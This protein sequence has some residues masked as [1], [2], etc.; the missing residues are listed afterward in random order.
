MIRNKYLRNSVKSTCVIVFYYFIIIVGRHM[1]ICIYVKSAFDVGRY[2]RFNYSNK[3]HN[4]P[5]MYNNNKTEIF[6]LWLWWVCWK[7]HYSYIYIYYI[8]II[9]KRLSTKHSFFIYTLLEI[10]NNTKGLVFGI[11]VS[12]LCKD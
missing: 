7:L 8:H 1:Y 11:A 5:A 4:R 6:V 12:D 9:I 3:T 2:T 10:F